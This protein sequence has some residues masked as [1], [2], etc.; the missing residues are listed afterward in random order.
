MVKRRKEG[1][2]TDGGKVQ[3]KDYHREVAKERKMI[4]CKINRHRYGD[5]ITF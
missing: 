5:Y 2:L 4:K 1:I 3:K